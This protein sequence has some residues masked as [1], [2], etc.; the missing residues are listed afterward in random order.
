MGEKQSDIYSSVAHITDGIYHV[1]K[2]I[3]RLSKVELYVDGIQVK[4][5]GGDRMLMINMIKI[6]EG[7][8]FFFVLFREFTSIR[9]TN[10]SFTKTFTYWKF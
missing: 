3:R 1:I 8:K 7:L 2:I 10:I 6:L 4:L 5:D 9:T